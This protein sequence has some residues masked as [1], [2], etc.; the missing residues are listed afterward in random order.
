MIEV[1][2]RAIRERVL[3]VFPS[4]TEEEYNKFLVLLNM[5]NFEDQLIKKEFTE[6]IKK[7]ENSENC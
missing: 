1:D 4:V 7:S 5:K 6:K 3:K 2:Y